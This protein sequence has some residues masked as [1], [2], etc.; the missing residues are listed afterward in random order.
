[1]H[2]SNSARDAEETAERKGKREARDAKRGGAAARR[3][4]T[5]L[6]DADAFN[7]VRF[8]SCVFPCAGGAG[9]ARALSAG[10]HDIPAF[11]RLRCDWAAPFRA[12][13]HCRA[14]A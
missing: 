10:G 5:E 4:P 9:V 7:T 13:R 1:V 8:P 6:D 3:R 11:L 12:V 2:A 14:R